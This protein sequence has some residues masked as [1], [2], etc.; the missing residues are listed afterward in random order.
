M[1]GD[2][3]YLVDIIEAG[4]AIGRMV[5]NV[6]VERF[7]ADDVLISAVEMK[8][9]VIAEALG[10]LTDQTRSSMMD[11]PVREVRALRNRI[12]HGYFNVDE[13]IIYDV[14]TGDVPSLVSQAEQSLQRDFPVTF[15]RLEERRARGDR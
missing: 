11:V 5:Q 9:V 3:L 14:A 8:L 1:R 10:S 7:V 4:D 13:R 15:E 6:P 12:V 2:D